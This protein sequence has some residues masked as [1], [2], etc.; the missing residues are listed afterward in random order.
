M[1]QAK[2]QAM[3]QVMLQVMLQVKLPNSFRINENCQSKAD[4]IRV[5]SAMEDALEH[6]RDVTKMI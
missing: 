2:L 5:K 4:S 6:F 3:S 1:K